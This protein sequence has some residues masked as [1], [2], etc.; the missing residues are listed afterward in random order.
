MIQCGLD[1]QIIQSDMKQQ[2]A[3]KSQ[4]INEIK[5]K[6]LSFNLNQL[7]NV[8]QLYA[9]CL[10]LFQEDNL[11]KFY[12][13][14]QKFHFKLKDQVGNKND[15]E[16][17]TLLDQKDIKLEKLFDERGIK[18]QLPIKTEVFENFELITQPI[19]QLNKIRNDQLFNINIISQ[20][21]EAKLPSAN[22]LQELKSQ[23]KKRQEQIENSENLVFKEFDSHQG[24]FIEISKEDREVKAK[25]LELKLDEIKEQ[26]RREKKQQEAEQR[27]IIQELKMKQ[28]MQRD[29]E[30]EGSSNIRGGGMG[31]LF[32]ELRAKANK[33]LQQDEV[34][35]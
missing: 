26:E 14:Q 27:S 17:S 22:F 9:K 15:S 1:L 8:Q 31:D 29:Q 7:N 19:S 11:E 6:F 24:K 2:L 30:D 5:H 4:N 10:S 3:E 35:E 16:E 25:Q 21:E 28:F 33:N 13:E 32:A 18:S 20:Q 34:F 12:E 23:L